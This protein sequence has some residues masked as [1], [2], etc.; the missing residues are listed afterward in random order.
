MGE[1]IEGDYFWLQ[2]DKSLDQEFYFFTKK[3]PGALSFLKWAKERTGFQYRALINHGGLE[4]VDSTYKIFEN[5][6]VSGEELA[7]CMDGNIPIIQGVCRKLIFQIGNAKELSKQGESH[8]IGRKLEP[9]RA[10]IHEFI[11]ATLDAMERYDQYQPVPELHYLLG[12]ILSPGVSQFEKSRI[13]QD[14]GFLC[15]MVAASEYHRMKAVPSY[16]ELARRFGVAP[17]TISRMFENRMDFEKRVQ[18]KYEFHSR[19]NSEYWSKVWWARK[20]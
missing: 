9:S 10:A 3:N 1:Q 5:F 13:S 20:D 4:F 7:S 8:L 2:H 12:L 19:H 11:L 14:F 16:R 18:N 15:E 6:N 17:S